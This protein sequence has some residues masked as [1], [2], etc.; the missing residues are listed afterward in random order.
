MRTAAREELV[1]TIS[2]PPE[3]NIVLD[4]TKSDNVLNHAAGVASPHEIQQDKT[5]AVVLPGSS[6]ITG[7]KNELDNTIKISSSG[8]EDHHPKYVDCNA[9]AEEEGWCTKK[10][11][12]FITKVPRRCS[13]QRVSGRRCD[14]DCCQYESEGRGNLHGGCLADARWQRTEERE[15]EEEPVNCSR[16]VRVSVNEE[17]E[18]LVSQPQQA[19]PVVQDCSSDALQELR[20]QYMELDAEM[21]WLSHVTENVRAERQRVRDAH[22]SDAQQRAVQE[23]VNTEEMERLIR[24]IAAKE[25]ELKAARRYAAHLR[26]ILLANNITGDFLESSPPTPPPLSF[27]LPSLL[28]QLQEQSSDDKDN[29]DDV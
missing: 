14:G 7:S 10:E 2:L 8:V 11:A 26:S 23:R 5:E 13:G 12:P 20:R 17:R 1:E 19:K 18:Q 4:E 9:V 29:K 22:A 27:S 28:R 6:S 25:A 16:H 3:D 24:N 21:A 15:E